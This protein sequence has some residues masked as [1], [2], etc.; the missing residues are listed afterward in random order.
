[1]AGL[2]E[3]QCAALDTRGSTLKESELFKDVKIRAVSFAKAGKPNE[4]PPGERP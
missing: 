4:T 3:V 2:T 1:M